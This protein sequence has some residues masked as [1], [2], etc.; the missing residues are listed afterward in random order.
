MALG[1]N[2]STV[3]VT[4]KYVNFEGEPIEGQIRFT[5]SSVLRNGI[6]DQIVA[7]SSIVVPLNEGSFTVTLPATN[8]P[9]IVPDSFQYTVEES[10]PGGRTYL[11]SLPYDTVGTLDLND[12]SPSPTISEY[13]SSA[14]DQTSWNTLVANINALDGEIDQGSGTISSSVS[15]DAIDSQ[16]ATYDA[17][18]LAFSSYDVLKSSIYTID[19]SYIAPYI[20]SAQASKDSALVS[21]SNA[22]NS[23]NAIINTLLFI[24]G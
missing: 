24:G 1:T 2:L 23:A 22:T 11:I 3:N 6:D 19:D 4:G 21:L 16:Y 18:D 5:L 13:F 14:V 12:I 9:D 10:F 15:Y 20:I 8:D 7:P 17:I